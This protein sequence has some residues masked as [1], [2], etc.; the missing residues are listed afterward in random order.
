MPIGVKEK[1]L[2]V[3][4]SN[5]TDYGTLDD[6]AFLSGYPVK[7]T[8]AREQEILDQTIRFYPPL[9]QE[10]FEIDNSEYATGTVQVLEDFQDI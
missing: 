8:V 3:A 7:A 10:S 4:M 9:E 1:V 6:I 5:P 2:W